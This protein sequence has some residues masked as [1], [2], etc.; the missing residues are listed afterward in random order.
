MFLS[1]HYLLLPTYLLV[2]RYIIIIIMA[3]E[4]RVFI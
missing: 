2:I 1:A 4:T 3:Q